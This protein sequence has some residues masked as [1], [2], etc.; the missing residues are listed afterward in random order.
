M[1]INTNAMKQLRWLW[2]TVVS[3]YHIT[4]GALRTLV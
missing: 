2:Q 3:L 4:Y 1:Y